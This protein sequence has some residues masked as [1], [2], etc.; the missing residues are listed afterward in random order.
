VISERC[1]EMQENKIEP[2]VDVRRLTEYFLPRLLELVALR[3]SVAAVKV[4]REQII[5]E[6]VRP[7]F[8]FV[9]YDL[10]REA[11]EYTIVLVHLCA[12]E[13]NLS[14]AARTLGIHRSTLMRTIKRMHRAGIDYSPTFIGSLYPRNQ[15]A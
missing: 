4:Q 3:R 8:G 10:M 1:D 7:L 5:G 14:H 15:H 11:L 9:S 6:L 13:G 12:H 2:N